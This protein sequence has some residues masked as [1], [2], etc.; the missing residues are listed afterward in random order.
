M[1]D[2]NITLWEGKFPNGRLEVQPEDYRED[3]F[4]THT[5]KKI[6]VIKWNK[7]VKEFN[8]VSDP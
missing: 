7:A 3:I 8:I 1:Q 6:V 4:Y 2:L 5:Q